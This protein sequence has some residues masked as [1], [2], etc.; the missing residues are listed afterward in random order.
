MFFKVQNLNT[1]HNLSVSVPLTYD[2]APYMGQHDY[3][4]KTAAYITVPPGSELL[5]TG[6]NCFKVFA[7]AA[8]AA[9]SVWLLQRLLGG[10]KSAVTWT[11]LTM[12]AGRLHAAR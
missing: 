9:E 7:A 1:T 12:E 8:A 10:L 4:N 6:P 2:H 11:L 3:L 5:L